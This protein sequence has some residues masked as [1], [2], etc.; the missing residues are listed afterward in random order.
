MRA[1]ALSLLALLACLPARAGGTAPHPLDGTIWNV[2]AGERIDREALARRLAEADIAILG[3]THDNAEQHRAQA[4]LIGRLHPAG[5]AFEMIPRAKEAAVAAHLA[6][7][8]EPGG[9]GP[10]IG[11]EES[12]WPDWDLYRPLFEAW[13]PEVYTGGGLP[14]DA[15]REAASAGAAALALDR[16][17]AV[18]AEPLDLATR[19]ALE[20]EMIAAH[21]DRLPRDAAAG[22]VEVQRLR[23]ASFADAALRAHK[24]GG[25]TV[26]VTGNGHARTDRGVPAYLRAVTPELDVLSVGLLETDPDGR[27]PSDYDTPYDFVWFTAPAEREDPCASFRTGG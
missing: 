15:L 21:C 24:A 12:G 25:S 10:A 9:L 13:R 17:A 5:I 14:R 19:A 11:W 2:A 1:L 22:M 7:G 20:D 27:V 23:D 6:A 16:F 4:W 3:E 8:G 26:L 18:L